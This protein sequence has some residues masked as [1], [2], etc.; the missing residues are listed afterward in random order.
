MID[1]LN[2]SIF[3]KM[4]YLIKFISEYDID[5]EKS[6]FNLNGLELLLII[7]SK[8]CQRKHVFNLVS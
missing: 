2:P 4:Y 7:I 1:Q 3:R 6:K 8:Y 5:S